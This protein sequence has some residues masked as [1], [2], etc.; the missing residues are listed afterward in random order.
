MLLV[1][2]ILAYYG[3]SP[4]FP[5]FL[6]LYEHKYC[7]NE[8]TNSN[9]EN[10]RS[11]MVASLRGSV[12]TG[13]EEDESCIGRFWAA[14]IHHVTACSGL[15]ARFKTDEPFI[16]LIFQFFF[17]GSGKPWITETADT[18]SA[19]TVVRLSVCVCVCVC[20]CV[21]VDYL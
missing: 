13:I 12:S 9:N 7:D 16:S 1:K 6:L 3:Y 19:D 2:N 5:F 18:E 14:G 21:F 11:R 17:S 4:T 20:V 15:G 10:A 8:A